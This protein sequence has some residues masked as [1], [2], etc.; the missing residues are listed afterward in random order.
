M[1][2]TETKKN[3]IK[4]KKTTYKEKEHTEQNF[5]CHKHCKIKPMY[6]IL[7]IKYFYLITTILVN[8]QNFPI[9][10]PNA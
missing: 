1:Q 4:Q 6:Q 2:T 5:S 8:L 3:K 10:R 9:L 7:I